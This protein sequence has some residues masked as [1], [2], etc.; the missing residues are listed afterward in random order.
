MMATCWAKRRA[1]AV[2]LALLPLLMGVGCGKPKGTVKGT[3][4]YKDKD[5]TYKFLPGGS[6]A[7]IP[8]ESGG[9]GGTFDINPD[10]G[11]YTA[12]N[13]TAGKMKVI[14]KPLI[15]PT[16]GRGGGGGGRGGG[17]PKDA[18]NPK[19]AGIPE[20]VKEKLDPT[21]SKG[22]YVPIDP[23]YQTPDNTPLEFTVEEGEQTYDP[24][25]D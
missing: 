1:A 7:F 20:D 3:V 9:R 18:F 4:Y 23:K 11:T 24:K 25:V 19:D 5:G 16:G 13:L 15:T 17:P 2:L 12:G 14:V 22:K 21:K 6:I 10:D 8:V